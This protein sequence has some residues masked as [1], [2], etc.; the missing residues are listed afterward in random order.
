MRI[1]QYLLSQRNNQADWSLLIIRV[2]LGALMAH[3]GLGKLLNFEQYST[4]FPDPIGLGP[5]LSLTLVVIAEF[6]GG[7]AV[8]L[9]LFT[10]FFL[11]LMIITMAVALFI[12][13]ANDPFNTKEL[14]TVFLLI[15]SGLFISGAGKYAIDSQI[16]KVIKK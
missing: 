13:H 15:A 7:I 12:V 9:G 10:R 11:F 4:Q 2:T 6:F 5:F 16:L 14:A 3:H 1:L 8:I